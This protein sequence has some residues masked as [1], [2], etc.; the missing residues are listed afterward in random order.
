[1]KLKRVVREG[2]A[3]WKG[4]GVAYHNYSSATRITY[5][6]PLNIIVAI[7]RRVWIELAYKFTPRIQRRTLAEKYFQHIEICE[8]RVRQADERAEEYRRSLKYLEQ[9][10]VMYRAAL[11]AADHTLHNLDDSGV[12]VSCGICKILD[13][14]HK[15]K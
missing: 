3:C 5:P 12:L 8:R 6:V 7:A 9:R 11:E 10:T 1:M 2:E 13:K 14:K 15:S 4:H